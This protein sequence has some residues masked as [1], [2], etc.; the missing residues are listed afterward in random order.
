MNISSTNS[1]SGS[2]PGDPFRA[3]RNDDVA[4]FAA[5]DPHNASATAQ[6]P[7]SGAQ[8]SAHSPSKRLRAYAKDVAT[9]IQN[10]LSSRDLSPRQR[11]EVQQQAEKFRALM[12]R[13]E[14]AFLP[15]QAAGT[16]FQAT[17]DEIGSIATSI[18]KIVGGKPMGASPSMP[19]GG[20]DTV[21]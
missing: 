9:R 11:A 19:N 1:V 8:T 15:G 5:T 17:H 6:V 14:G 13:L 21:A 10:A 20:L 4:K 7:G 12:H 16:S 18:D 2:T 3:A